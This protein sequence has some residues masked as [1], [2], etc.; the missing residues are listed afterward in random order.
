MLQYTL[1]KLRNKAFHGCW[2][3]ARFLNSGCN[4]A[5]NVTVKIVPRPQPEP[6]NTPQNAIYSTFPR[7]AG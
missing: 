6:K 3:Q 5:R 4:T 1:S 2:V 7:N